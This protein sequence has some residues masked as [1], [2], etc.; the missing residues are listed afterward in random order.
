VRYS[1]AVE[2]QGSYIRAKL[3]EAKDAIGDE[4]QPMQE[5]LWRAYF[6]LSNLDPRWLPDTDEREK[7]T[8]VMEELEQYGE[9]HEGPAPSRLHEIPDEKAASLA[10]RIAD[11]GDRYLA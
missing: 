6:S 5:R 1:L 4:G 7:L 3:R 10:E 11:V 8:A 2:S 9:P